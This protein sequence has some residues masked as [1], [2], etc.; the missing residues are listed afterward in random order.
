MAKLP[1]GTTVEMV[2]SEMTLAKRKEED[3]EGPR[4]LYDTQVTA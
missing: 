2:R 3:A 1:K 4:F